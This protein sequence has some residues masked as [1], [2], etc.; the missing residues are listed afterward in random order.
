MKKRYYVLLSAYARIA[1]Q[2]EFL[3]AVSGDFP[4]PFAC[5]ERSLWGFD[6]TI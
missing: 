6:M 1:N 4:V 5:R 2:K 3:Q